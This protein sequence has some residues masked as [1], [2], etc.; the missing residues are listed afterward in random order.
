MVD[1]PNFDY[2][3]VSPQGGFMPGMTLDRDEKYKFMAWNSVGSVAVKQDEN[4]GFSVIQIEFADKSFHKNLII[5]NQ[6]NASIGSLNYCGAFL[7]SKG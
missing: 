3:G 2:I 7:A 5:G 4:S 6:M 1:N